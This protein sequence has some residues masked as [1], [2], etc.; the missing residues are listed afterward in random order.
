MADS[1]INEM[2]EFLGLLRA[3]RAAIELRVGKANEQIGV[4][5]EAMDEYGI[6]ELHN[7]GEAYLYCHLLPIASKTPAT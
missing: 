2:E 7:C 6:P 4:I 1:E 3:K 5:H